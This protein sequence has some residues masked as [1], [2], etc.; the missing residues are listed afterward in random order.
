MIKVCRFRVSQ[1]SPCSFCSEHSA[2]STLWCL[3]DWKF[4]E[5]GSSWPLDLV[6]EANQSDQ[7]LY[8]WGSVVRASTSVAS[9]ARNMSGWWLLHFKIS[10][11]SCGSFSSQKQGFKKPTIAVGDTGWQET[12]PLTLPFEAFFS[13]EVQLCGLHGVLSPIITITCQSSSLMCFSS[14]YPAKIVMSPWTNWP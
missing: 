7:T 14:S 6:I 9:S 10:V 8:G 5:V 11:Q 13:F 2:D 1:M 4:T 12:W 3:S